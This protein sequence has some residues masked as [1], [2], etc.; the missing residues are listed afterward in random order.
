[1]SLSAQI[2]D[3]RV[4]GIVEQQSDAFDNELRVGIDEPRRRS[5]A[6]VFLVAKTA[7]DL[8][9]EQTLDG[10]VDGGNDFGVDALY[11]DSPEDG[12][13]RVNLVQG[14][15]RGDLRGNAA[16]P[17]TGIAQMIDAVGALFDP[18]R[19]VT[20]NPR[21]EQRV[22]D[23]RSFVKDGAIPRVTAVAANNG[24]TWTEQ[25]QQRIDGVAR[26]LGGQVEWRHLGPEELL[27]L[28][29]TRKPI[30][31]D[32]QLTGHATVETF[33]FRRALTGRMSVAELARLTDEYGNRLFEKNIRRYLGLAG[34][35]VNEAVAATLR[36]PAQRPSFYF[37]NNGITITCS[38]F[39]HNALQRENW[40]VKV[41]GLQIVNGGQTART[42]QHL[43]QEVGA[44]IRD[45]EVLV[46]IYELQENDV[47]LVESITFATNSQNPVDLRDL[48]A[49]D[50]R[51]ATLGQ[52]ISGLGY[53]YRAKR[54]ERA[55][56]SDEFTSA[57]IAEAVL[58]VW[59]HRPHQAR[60]RSREHFGALYR[61]IFTD[62]LNGSQA[63]TAA[64]LHRHAEN[65]RK[66]PPNDAPDF[67]AYGSR[68]IAMMMGRYLLNDLGITLRQ[69]DHRNFDAARDLVDRNS[70]GYLA[71]AQE[72][73]AGALEPLFRGKGR[74]RTL[75]RL[76]ATFR[77]A[78]LV[79]TLL[80]D[81]ERAP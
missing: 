27:A 74:E 20:L 61:T 47:E 68:F 72:R 65:R 71:R 81:G 22:E 45:A 10:I 26:D 31:A 76:S 1:M 42:V 49:N 36:E 39:R 29:Q 7:F 15:Y 69:L 77:R 41:E 48:K 34:N 19:P 75:Q 70:D 62:D 73:I 37:Y 43:A 67:L 23:V 30:N 24:T 59:R 64:L 4:A 80:E 78:D 58:A 8:T 33:D 18:T 11:C 55:V 6:F 51:Q 17:E 25:A 57:V 32:V 79:D 28:L 14:K 12:E 35:R 63:V 40:T 66:R 2:I 56:S 52:S 21:L 44:A 9:D 38:K 54:E 53:A 60:F 46:R 3:Q 16:F 13:I 5:V 50:P